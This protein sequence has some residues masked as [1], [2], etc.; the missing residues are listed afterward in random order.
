MQK[1]SIRSRLSKVAFFTILVAWAWYRWPDGPEILNVNGAQAQVI[2][3]DSFKT[4]TDEFRIYGIDAPEYRQICKD[5]KGN[6]WDCGKVA[7]SGLEKLLRDKSHACEVTARDQYKR[8]IATCTD[9]AGKNLGAE[10][11]RQGMAQ[12]ADSYGSIVFAEEETDAKN[13][14]RGIW[15]G[16]FTDPKIWRSEHSR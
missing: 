12:S 1:H 14:K 16:P 11:V 3:G 4:A 13:A 15:K 10:L 6:D 8:A 9:T 7:R 5:G 2:D